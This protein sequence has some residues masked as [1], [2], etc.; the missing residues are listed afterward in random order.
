MIKDLGVVLQVYLI[1]LGL[2]F[3][4][5]PC[6]YKY[7]TKLTDRGFAAGR[8]ILTLGVSSIIWWLAFLKLPVNTSGGIFGV[9]TLVTIITWYIA[10]KEVK[11]A[12]TFSGVSKRLILIEEGLFLGG[13]IIFA[14]VRAHQPDILGLEKF[15]DFGFINSYRHSP[16]LPASDMWLAGEAINYYSFGHFWA[17]VWLRLWQ[18]TPGVGYNLMLAFLF[19]TSLAMAFSLVVNLG[20]KFNLRSAVGGVVG[21][22][23][24]AVAGNSHTI[25]TL[26]TKRSLDSYWYADATRFIHNTIHEFPSYSFVVSDLHAHV[27][28]LPLVLLFLLLLSLWLREKRVWW[29]DVALGWLLGLLAMTNTWDVATY[30]L[31][32]VVAMGAKIIFG[33]HE[34][35]SIL[36]SLGIILG[37]ALMTALF[38]FIG[39]G[40]I[41]NGIGLVT[42]RSPIW[43]LLFLWTGHVLMVILAAVSN[44]KKRP[45]NL[46]VIALG[47]TAIM[48]LIIPEVVYA[49]DIYL[50][51]PRANTM[52]K[53]TFQA[54]VMMSILGG[55]VAA[56]TR[57]GSVAMLLITGGLMLF[58]VTA[59]KSYY[60]DF[61]EYKGLDGMAYLSLADGNETEM[62]DY[63]DKHRDGKNLVEAVGD[64]FTEYNAISA[65]T[66]IPTVVGWRAHEWLWRGSYDEV[67][68]REAEV[69][70]IYAN[71]DTALTES[72]IKK[73]RIGWIVISRREREKYQID[74][75]GLKRGGEVVWQKNGEVLIKISE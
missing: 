70:Q 52:F 64:S 25:S 46:M 39:F 57:G 42:E 44:I 19:G 3:L 66:G 63:L 37:V 5:W 30:G 31:L 32:L 71:N 26:L 29:L 49:K 60:G 58:P 4:I 50:S 48:L 69:S 7:L 41:S 14:W 59:Y 55:W 34:D 11:K 27:L 53:L 15:M 75:E 67:G 62:I 35:Y 72:L 24:V 74:E 40:S 2:Q 1:L 36:I 6:L 8:V 45:K 61:K 33:E 20:K 54:F 22:I 23:L 10:R 17:S 47:V 9:L 28:G 12:F 65:Y 21:A 56:Q 68:K 38:W 16:T 43:Q 51:H 73:Y 13:L 18:V